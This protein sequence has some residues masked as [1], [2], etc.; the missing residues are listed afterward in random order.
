MSNLRALM[1]TLELDRTTMPELIERMRAYEPQ[2]DGTLPRSYPGYPR[3]A[4]PGVRPRAFTRLDRTLTDRR[5]HRTVSPA[6]PKPRALA[7]LLRFGHGAF[8]PAPSAGGLQ[9]IELY[10]IALAGGWLAPAAYHYD[11]EG[12]ALARVAEHDE[13]WSALIPS[14][15]DVPAAPLALVLAG[16]GAKIEPKY[17]ARAAKLLL[18][19]AGH[20]MQDLCLVAASLDLSVVPLGG[21]Y[22]EPIARA[23]ALPGSDAVLY[24]AA[25][26][27][28]V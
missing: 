27:A 5:C 7:R 18:L 13:P 20:V 22:E 28:V 19:E 14:L 17:G 15:T 23:L 8:S 10:V 21:F 26:G 3:V 11:R 9:A 2:P 25:C 16:D 12:H 1:R 4:L 6:Q 24:A